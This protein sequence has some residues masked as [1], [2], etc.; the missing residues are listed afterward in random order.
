MTWRKRRPNI[1]SVCEQEYNGER[2]VCDDCWEDYIDNGYQEPVDVRMTRRMNDRII[3]G[4][5][6]R[7][8]SDL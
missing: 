6:M 1:C 2:A 4:N 3:E 8:D 7:N 5:V